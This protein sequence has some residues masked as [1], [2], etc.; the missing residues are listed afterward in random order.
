[1][2]ARSGMARG[3]ALVL[4]AALASCGYTAGMRV[5]ERNRSVGVEI[6]GNETFERD[7][8]RPL[9]DEIS[10]ALRDWSDA[11]LVDPR[12]ADVV[13]RG[14]IESYHKRSGIR[15]TTNVPLESGVYIEVEAALWRPG[16]T[17]PETGPI[18]AGTW[19]GFVIG[20]DENERSARDR[21]L[22]HV[23]E[24]IVLDLL[25]PRG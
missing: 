24:R 8:E 21:A 19:V 2:T 20:P 3:V 6:F 23:A 18:R 17:R 13:L 1:M 11:A 12:R 7:L 15:S 16:A 10:R 22:R 25:A 14:T 9:A 5:A 4:A